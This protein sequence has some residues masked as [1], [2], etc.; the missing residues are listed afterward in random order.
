[1]P[2]WIA[3]SLLFLVLFFAWSLSAVAAEDERGLKL[4]TA[5]NAYDGRD[6]ARAEKLL[7][8]LSVS[9][10]KDPIMHYLLGN[11]YLATSKMQLA[12]HEY[13]LCLK[14]NPVPSLSVQCH[15]ALSGIHHITPPPPILGSSPVPPSAPGSVAQ[16]LPAASQPNLAINEEKIAE[17]QTELLQR[18]EDETK[19][20]LRF[21]RKLTDIA[22]TRLRDQAA[23]DIAALP[24]YYYDSRGHRRSDPNYYSAAR[25]IT[26][27]CE[28]KVQRQ[29]DALERDNVVLTRVSQQTKIDVANMASTLRNTMLSSRGASR[30]MPAGTNLYVRNYVNF[31]DSPD[32]EPQPVVPL[33]AQYSRD[34]VQPG[35][36]K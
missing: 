7:N 29:Q 12:E 6:F 10:P 5:M 24:K 3:C 21:H 33:H 31:G 8:E 36:V 22:V 34:R 9:Y 27:E 16:P 25:E 35:A 19:Q 30:L 1:M 20:S 23:L 14:L 26:A 28:A 4:H 18:Q 17:E 11:C 2:S 13:D 15:T 32:P